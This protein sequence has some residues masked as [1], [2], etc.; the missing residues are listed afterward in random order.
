MQTTLVSL[1]RFA[2]PNEACGLLSLG[3]PEVNFT[4]TNIHKDPEHQFEF[5][6]NEYWAIRQLIPRELCLA[7]HS[8]PR[9]RASPSEQDLALMQRIELPMAIISLRAR[10]PLIRI[11]TCDMYRLKSTEVGSYRLAI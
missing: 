10:I 3:D 6:W 8:H 11:F 1:S 5:D 7:W 4:L 2:V 9:T